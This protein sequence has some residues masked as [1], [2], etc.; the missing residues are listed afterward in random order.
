MMEAFLKIAILDLRELIG[1]HH[2]A[3]E[4]S[5]VSYCHTDH[6]SELSQAQIH[7]A[8]AERFKRLIRWIEERG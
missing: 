2:E 1:Q 4:F 7:E 8:K 6:H 5:R 3:A